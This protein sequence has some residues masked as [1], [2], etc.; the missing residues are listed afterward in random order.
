MLLGILNFLDYTG[1]ITIDDVEIS[2]IPP[3]LLRWRIP[4]IS[5]DLLDLDETVRFTV[6]PWTNS[7]SK[8]E[9][10][11][12]EASTIDLLQKLGLWAIIE[13]K[14]GLDTK[15]A[16]LGLSQGQQQLLSIARGIMRQQ[17]TGTKVVLMDEPTGMLDLATDKVVQR[18]FDERLRGCTI[19]TVA[20]RP[21]SIIRCHTIYKLSDGIDV[22]RSERRQLVDE[23]QKIALRGKSRPNAGRNR[24]GAAG[25]K[26]YVPGGTKMQKSLKARR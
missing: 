25:R 13:A 26:R 19:I 16:T 15:V 11:A 1:S 22:S 10:E 6:C 8:E 18:L 3:E 20:H 14:D 23:G 2:A 21:Q 9:Y 24:K 7:L 4:T 17:I 12:F 5:Q